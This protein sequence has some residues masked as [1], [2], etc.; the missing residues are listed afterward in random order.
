M[1]F[2]FW[3]IINDYFDLKM[4]VY[5]PWCESS[6]SRQLL[7]LPSFFNAEWAAD[8]PLHRPTLSL[9]ILISPLFTFGSLD[10]A[11]GAPKTDRVHL[12]SIPL[13]ESMREPFQ[14][15]KLFSP[16]GFNRILPCILFPEC[17]HSLPPLCLCTHSLDFL[18]L[19]LL[20]L[21]VKNL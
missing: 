18:L 8:S 15:W 21:M 2:R 9:I 17:D 14:F 6:E 4:M 13:I 7:F 1:H 3:C 12:K 11:F 20:T 16:C 5:S 19:A 10:F